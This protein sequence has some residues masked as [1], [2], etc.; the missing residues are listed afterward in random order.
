MASSSLLI[1]P[2]FVLYQLAHGKGTL[3]QVSFPLENFLLLLLLLVMVL[4]VVVV[5]RFVS[6]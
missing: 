1:I 4:V 5:V 2:I 6:T 3:Q